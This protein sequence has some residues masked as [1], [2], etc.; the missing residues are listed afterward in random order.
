MAVAGW[1]TPSVLG[2]GRALWLASTSPVSTPPSPASSW[3]CSRRPGVP[4]RARRRGGRRPP[5]EQARPH[6]RT[7][8]ARSL[9]THR[10]PSPTG[11]SPLLHPW[12][13]YL[14]VPIFALA[15]AG[16]ELDGDASAQAAGLHRR[17]SASSPASRWASP[18][19]WLATLGSPPSRRCQLAPPPRCRRSLGSASPCRSSSPASP[20]D[21]ELQADAKTGILAASV[22]AAVL[23]AAIMIANG[24]HPP[25]S[26]MADR[27]PL[28]AGRAQD[29]CASGAGGSASPRRVMM[30]T[31]RSNRS[32]RGRSG[33]ARGV[34]VRRGG[35][36]PRTLECVAEPATEPRRRHG[37][38]AD[39]RRLTQTTRPTL[40]Y[41]ETLRVAPQP[42][43]VVSPGRSPDP[44]LEPQ[45]RRLLD[46][47]PVAVASIL[48][49]VRGR[50]E[51]RI[52]DRQLVIACRCDVTGSF[53]LLRR[54]M[55]FGP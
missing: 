4:D 28:G 16:I 48:L 23:G 18:A 24:R 26:S 29:R 21:A 10:S 42:G 51:I 22:V 20:S 31:R 39:V 36:L 44:E 46:G 52:D 33:R 50:A 8:G 30:A 54:C 17:A 19:T 32:R 14:I 38:A 15:N 11:S 37:T 40:T 7:C 25:E 53:L 3:D 9:L 2:V 55:R 12:T 1:S 43:R 35:P 45:P 13:S 5:R 47:W 27:N 49:T 6:A 34:V 41:D